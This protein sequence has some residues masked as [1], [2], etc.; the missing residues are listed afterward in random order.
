MLLRKQFTETFAYKHGADRNLQLMKQRFYKGKVEEEVQHFTNN[1]CPCV[2][3]KKPHIQGKASL[4]PLTSSTT[5]LEISAIDFLHLKKF[6]KDFEYIF[7]LLIISQDIH[8][9]F[10]FGI[11]AQLPHDQGGESKNTHFQI[12]CNLVV[13]SKPVNHYLPPKGKWPYWKD[14]WDGTSNVKNPPREI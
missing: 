14:K 8:L 5:L 11:L 6:S 13:Y 2:R 7:L 1:Q 9:F 10:A 12:S 4:L 3:Q